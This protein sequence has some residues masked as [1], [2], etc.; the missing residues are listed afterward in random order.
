MDNKKEEGKKVDI[1]EDIKNAEMITKKLVLIKVLG[2]LKT[3]A[4]TVLEAKEKCSALLAEAGV[5][6]EESKRVID[7][8]NS[9]SSVQ[10]TKADKEKIED[11]AKSKIEGE[12]KTVER[13][14]EDD[15]APWLNKLSSIGGFGVSGSLGGAHNLIG[16]SITGGSGNGNGDNLTTV[17]CSSSVEIVNDAGENLKIHL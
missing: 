12:R 13:K 11:W 7:F 5:S 14:L 2:E 17:Y 9:K 15:F 1:L 8:I 10:L 3:L 6:A 4:K 16:S